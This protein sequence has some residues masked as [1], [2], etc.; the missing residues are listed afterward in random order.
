[1]EEELPTHW[2][3]EKEQM[4][5]KKY[6]KHDTEN[7]PLKLRINVDDPEELTVPAPIATLF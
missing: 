3:K 1:M 7:D 4:N 5:E 2:W 6:R